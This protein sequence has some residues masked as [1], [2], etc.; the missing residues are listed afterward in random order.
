MTS[1][2]FLVP[3]PIT[4]W[5]RQ[6]WGFETL[7]AHGVEPRVLDL[8]RVL[9]T[10]AASE[11]GAGAGGSAS[12]ER[13]RSLREFVRIVESA[14]ASSV[15]IDYLRGISGPDLRSARVF[16]AL[17]DARAVYYVIAGGSLPSA[18]A[19][20]G[21][22]RRAAVRPARVVR[23]VAALVARAAT[24]RFGGYVPPAKVFGPRAPAVDAFAARHGIPIER[25]ISTPSLDYDV[26]ARAAARRADVAPCC[27]FVD[28]GLAGHPDFDAPGRRAADAATYFADL[29]RVFDRI[30]AATGHPVVVARHPRSDAMQS[31][32]IGGRTVLSASTADA[33]AASVLVIGH[34]STALGLAALARKP[35][36]L[37]GGRHV[38]DAGLGGLLAAMADALD[39]PVVDPDDAE[40]LAALR[41]DLSRVPEDRYARYVREH[42]RPSDAAEVSL[43]AVVAQHAIDDVRRRGAAR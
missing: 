26:L 39:A 34:A 43:W 13:P 42:V 35:V 4:A 33:V 20:R 38:A 28:D 9:G 36:L 18:A 5:D 14:A 41:P 40:A 23:H 27:V 25:R 3:R 29:C 15:F 10:A 31:E 1:A 2:V 30:E 32:L 24:E 7:R 22:L 8:S 6:R 21:R 37:I 11:E 16:R 12:A 17:R 19:T